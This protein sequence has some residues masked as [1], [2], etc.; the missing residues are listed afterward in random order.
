[1][2]DYNYF[3]KNID[4]MGEDFIAMKNSKDF[5]YEAPMIFRQLAKKRID[6]EKYGHYFQDIQFLNT[7]ITVAEE[8]IGFHFISANSIKYV[9]DVNSQSGIPVEP[10]Y[11]QVYTSHMNTYTAYQIVYDHLTKLKETKDLHY[12][13]YLAA[14]L[15]NNINIANA[16]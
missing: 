4:K 8:K 15:S 6:L 13:H 1:M 9:I 12:V 16:L 10:I 5:A 2:A 14:A 7:C 3:T 11:M